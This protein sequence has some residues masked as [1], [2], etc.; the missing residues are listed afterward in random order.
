MLSTIWVFKTRALA[1]RGVELVVF[2]TIRVVGYGLDELFLW[3]FI[4]PLGLHYMVGKVFSTG[5]VLTWHFA[6]R[7]CML[8]RWSMSSNKT[9]VIIGAGSAGPTAAYELLKHT[10]VHP[11]IYEPTNDIGTSR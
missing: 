7:K 10:D 11:V 9:A 2:G 8:F 6:A 1:N 4:Q 3:F 5:F